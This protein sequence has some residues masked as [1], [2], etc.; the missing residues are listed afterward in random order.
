MNDN[1]LASID[2]GSSKVCTL[3][4]ELTPEE[5]IRILGVG[6]TPAEGVKKGMVDNI[7]EA[8]DAIASSVEKAERS[9]GSRVV[10]A[11]VSIS[12][13][14]VN[15]LNNRG[16]ATI[17]GRERPISRPEIDRAIEEAQSLNLPTN[18][19]I[20]HVLPRF[21]VVDGQEHV[22]DPV[23]MYG[24]RLD[25]ETHIVSGSVTAIQNLTQCVEGAGVQ[26]EAL[27][28]AP[29]AAA[30]AVLEE[31]EK[32]QGVIV[33]DIGGGTTDIA[34]FVDGTVF[35]TS[36]LPVGGYHLTHDLVAGLRAPFSA[37][38]DLKLEYG[39]ALPSQ[40]NPEDTV[41]LEAFGGQ[42][43]KE[44]S[45]RRIAEILQ[46]RVE[47]ILE[48]IYI[49][50]KRAGFDE[51]IAAGL[52]LT[53]GSA[54]LP[55]IDELA[56]Q[57]LRTPVRIGTPRG[58]HGLADTLNS[59]AYAASVGLLRWSVLE[60]GHNGHKPSFNLNLKSPVQLGGLVETAKRWLKALIPQ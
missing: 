36:V 49:D 9:S 50:A 18:R 12:G 32:R 37:A 46:A 24:Q 16:V 51:M 35:H 23:G 54:S 30:E 60:N 8:T 41:E 22:S 15:S 1:V 45:R 55:G 39:S 44:V 59:P 58:I 43:R 53:G 27:V 21:F 20:L 48:M 31:E 14:H 17:P 33:A 26:V 56:E 57:V 13:N 42:R 47:E 25:M 52:V 10:S 5:D 38:E 19:E 6:V 40:I 3:V 11:H 2:V 34:V 29:L 4:G 28:L 7:H